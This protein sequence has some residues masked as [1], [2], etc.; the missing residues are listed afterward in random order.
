MAE[1]VPA[2]TAA[3]AGLPPEVTARLLALLMGALDD[4]LLPWS[5]ELSLH[6]ELHE[7]LRQHV[8]RVG[9]RLQLK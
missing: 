2:A 9:R 8:A 6:H 5:I 7:S 3:I 1:H 4:L